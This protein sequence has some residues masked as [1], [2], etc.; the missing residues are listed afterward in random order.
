MMPRPKMV[1]W[2]Q[3]AAGEHRDHAEQALLGAAHDLGHLELVDHRQGDVEADAVDGQEEDR[4]EDLLAQLL[5]LEDGDQPALAEGAETGLEVCGGRGHGIDSSG[6][7]YRTLKQRREKGKRSWRRLR[8]SG[9]PAP[10]AERRKRLIPPL[11]ACA[12]SSCCGPVSSGG[13]IT[14]V[15]PPLAAIFSAAD[16]EKWWALTV[17]FL[18]T[19]PL[20][21]MRTPSAGP[22]ARP[23]LRSVSASTV[24]PSSNALS[25]SPTLTT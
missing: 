2:L 9:P 12:A 15:V 14:S 17:S 7:G 1:L 6:C 11:S 25:R 20:P 23:T 22:L 4:D 21:R 13:G 18:V 5:D 3:A 16:F 10:G 24:A 8:L 19:S